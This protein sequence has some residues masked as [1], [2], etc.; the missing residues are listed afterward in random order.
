MAL[1][2]TPALLSCAGGSRGGGRGCKNQ[3]FLTRRVLNTKGV[4]DMSRRQEK[5]FYNDHIRD[6][7]EDPKKFVNTKVPDLIGARVKTIRPTKGRNFQ[8]TNSD[9]R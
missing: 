8:L 6:D 5:K 9:E 3:Y 4:A 2:L 1:T 7:T